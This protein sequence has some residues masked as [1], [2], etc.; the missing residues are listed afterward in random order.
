MKVWANE[1]CDKAMQT[2]G[3][4][5]QPIQN[6][7]LCAF[8]NVSGHEKGMVCSGDSGGPLTVKENGRLCLV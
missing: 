8:G 6:T 5:N 7:H 4:D 2:F 3:T 1:D